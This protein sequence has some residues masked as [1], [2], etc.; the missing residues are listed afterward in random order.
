MTTIRLSRQPIASPVPRGSFRR[1]NRP[2][3]WRCWSRCISPRR[4][5]WWSMFRDAGTRT[6]RPT[7]GSVAV[8]KTKSKEHKERKRRNHERIC[9]PDPLSGPPGRP[10][11]PGGHL[12]EG[13]RPVSPVGAAGEFGLPH[14]PEQFFVHRGGTHRFVYPLGRAHPAHVSRRYARCAS[15]G[16]RYGRSGRIV[17]LHPSIFG[18]GQSDGYQRFFRLHGLRCGAVF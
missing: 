4:T 6:W 3:H 8:L 7:S 11:N 16:G 18:A 12:P 17:R 10:S 15:G 5:S 9:I 1:W 13:T 14:H 2:M